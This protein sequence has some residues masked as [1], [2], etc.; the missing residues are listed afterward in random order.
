[1]KV[2]LWILTLLGLVLA[3]TGK[4]VSVVARDEGENLINPDA[5]LE[6]QQVIL[7]HDVMFQFEGKLF[8][9]E[10]TVFIKSILSYATLE[11][12][13]QQTRL[14]AAKLRQL[15]DN[16]T[17]PYE[18]APVETPE[19]EYRY[20]AV[21]KENLY[22]I[23]QARRECEKRDMRLVAP[24]D[25]TELREAQ[26][27]YVKR[28]NATPFDRIWID[29]DFDIVSSQ[30]INP[31][32]K[33]TLGEIYHTALELNRWKEVRD[34]FYK[35]VVLN[36][37]KGDLD[38][39]HINGMSGYFNSYQ[40]TYVPAEAKEPKAKIL[41]QTF[42]L[43]TSRASINQ[44]ETISGKVL[45]H[46]A[47]SMLPRKEI[48]ET[49]R[50]FEMIA[51]SQQ[52]RFNEIIT[53]YN[54]NQPLFGDTPTNDRQ[55]S[56]LQVLY[57][58]EEDKQGQGY[59]IHKEDNWLKAAI[60]ET[61]KRTKR[62]S[63]E[64]E[65]LG[66][67]L[68]KAI[69]IIGPYIGAVH[70]ILRIKNLNKYKEE[71]T[72]T[73]TKLYSQVTSHAREIA[74]IKFG[75]KEMRIQIMTMQNEI[76]WLY[77]VMV[78]VSLYLEVNAVIDRLRTKILAANTDFHIQC[79]KFERW[80]SQMVKGKSP[81]DL[82]SEDVLKELRNTLAGKGLNVK[83]TFQDT[84]SMIV[85]SLNR[86]Q[87]VTILSSVRAT[88]T[89]WTIYSVKSL[90][91]YFRGRLFRERVES[92]FIA[93][94]HK[95]TEYIQLS[96]QQAR[97]CKD[98]L[99]E[100]RGPRKNLAN[101]GCGTIAFKGDPDK[102]D[103]PVDELTEGPEGYFESIEGGLLYSLQDKTRIIITCPYD[104]DPKVR[105]ETISGRG[106][107]LIKPG[108]QASLQSGETYVGMPGSDLAVNFRKPVNSLFA[109]T[110]GLGRIQKAIDTYVTVAKVTTKLSQ[111]APQITLFAAV[112][113]AI[114]TII[115]LSC[116]MWKLKQNATQ[117]RNY[118]WA[119]QN[120]NE[121]GN[122]KKPKRS[123]VWWKF[124]S[125]CR[126][127]RHDKL[128]ETT[129]ATPA[130]NSHIRP[131]QR[132][133]EGVSLYVHNPEQSPDN[134]SSNNPR[135]TSSPWETFADDSGNGTSRVNLSRQKDENVPPSRN[136]RRPPSHNTSDRVS[137]TRDM[138]YPA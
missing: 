82:Y 30:M 88:G 27:V 39:V 120:D 114:I 68:G 55:S 51:I 14:I 49:Q 86:T 3:I 90:P 60:N 113:A 89:P 115:I 16:L 127:S 107:L 100:I 48:Q 137:L 43:D 23:R 80:I 18:P 99:C 40:W 53:K 122:G 109:S 78:D 76:S 11:E 33:Q 20:V 37:F 85:P 138:L 116:C 6:E 13:P 65:Q 95:Y 73:L 25:I 31:I 102:I 71:T 118:F 1:M 124:M 94:N 110:V 2:Y 24:I 117:L 97:M 44:A 87:S 67:N 98:D 54:L 92:P 46:R 7:A 61:I 34:D 63:I 135:L 26:S 93:V 45:Q 81:E 36:P 35:S 106:I 101:A 9:H 52:N 130:S 17:V 32:T 58:I 28:Y 57:E 96:D 56:H 108:C 19:E 79:E 134:I 5:Y 136:F 121:E 15:T 83:A 91:R 103:C 104:G 50:I 74:E 129:T 131:K 119:N 8:P 126:R 112:G 47:N 132:V 125:W 4:D 77:K 22:N 69:P 70:D 38:F 75:E 21:D 64:L 123:N 128:T 72:A 29:S 12:V 111:K 105:Y 41:C 10:S 59:K 42:N 84:E 62:E 66:W 133:D